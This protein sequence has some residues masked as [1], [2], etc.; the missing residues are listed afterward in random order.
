MQ[1][2]W[3]QRFVSFLTIHMPEPG[4]RVPA[5]ICGRPISQGA[6]LHD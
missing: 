3:A 1:T 2:G 5:Y 4:Y 6:D